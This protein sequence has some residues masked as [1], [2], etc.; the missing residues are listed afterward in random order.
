MSLLM[1]PFRL[2]WIGAVLKRR[3]SPCFLQATALCIMLNR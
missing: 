1:I 3:V 2:S